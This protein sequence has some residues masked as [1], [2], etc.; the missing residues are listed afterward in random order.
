[1]KTII[2]ATFT[3]GVRQFEQIKGIFKSSSQSVASFKSCSSAV[4][5]KRDPVRGVSMHNLWIKAHL[6]CRRRRYN[7]NILPNSMKPVLCF[8]AL[9]TSITNKI[10][11][12]FP[13]LGGPRLKPLAVVKNEAR[14]G[15]GSV[16]SSDICFSGTG[17]SNIDVLLTVRRCQKGWT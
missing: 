2:T 4:C 10:L 12:D 7:Q 9:V 11:Y 17:M 1:M 14:I 8:Q 13:L 6:S 16:F 3:S 5:I 15:I